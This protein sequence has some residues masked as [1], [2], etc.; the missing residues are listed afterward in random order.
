MNPA[1]QLR[2][3]AA[4]RRVQPIAY[5]FTQVSTS[6]QQNQ[7]EKRIG[8]TVGVAKQKSDLAKMLSLNPKG[9]QQLLM[10]FKD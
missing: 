5:N 3:A 2:L 7:S 6:P 4:T 9:A 8:P 10:Q 1:L